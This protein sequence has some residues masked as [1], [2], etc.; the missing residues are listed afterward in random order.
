MKLVKKAIVTALMIASFGWSANEY[1]AHSKSAEIQLAF[2]TRTY[3]VSKQQAATAAQ[4]ILIAERANP[5]WKVQSVKE[6]GIG[7]HMLMIKPR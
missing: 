7:W 1:I 3:N 4:A 6:L 2:N 5:G